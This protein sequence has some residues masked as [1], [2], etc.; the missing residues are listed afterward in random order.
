MRYRRIFEK[1]WPLRYT[2]R[3]FISPKAGHFSATRARQVSCGH[4]KS[5][6]GAVLEKKPVSD[7]AP[8]SIC[9]AWQL[10]LRAPKQRCWAV[11]RAEHLSVLREMLVTCGHSDLMRSCNHQAGT[12]SYEIQARFYS[13]LPPSCRFILS[14]TVVS[15]PTR[16]SWHVK[17]WTTPRLNVL[18]IAICCA[19]YEYCTLEGKIYSCNSRY[20]HTVDQ[21]GREMLYLLNNVSVPWGNF[22]YRNTPT[23]VNFPPPPPK[24]LMLSRRVIFVLILIVSI[25]LSTAEL[26]KAFN[27][28]YF[29]PFQ[30][31]NV[32]IASCTCYPSLTLKVA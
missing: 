22:S 24:K 16:Y 5:H 13:F 7:F 30:I 19:K 2:T 8:G 1:E 21:V 17:T 27:L 29:S 6:A 28:T 18:P 15:S 12:T 11:R 4:C 14:D 23:R 3:N 26:T 10:S 25:L 9:F 20:S 31:L 32:P